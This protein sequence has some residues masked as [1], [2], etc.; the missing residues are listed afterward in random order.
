MSHQATV[1]TPS[2]LLQ[3][4]NEIIQEHPDYISGMRADSVEQHR[5]TLVFKGE[6]FLDKDGIPTIKSTAAFNMFKHLAQ[7]LSEQYQL[8]SE[9]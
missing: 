8:K 6:F 1:I 4:A 3:K 9:D 7:V 2:E 5:E